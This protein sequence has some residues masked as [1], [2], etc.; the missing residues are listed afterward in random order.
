MKIA[1][2]VTASL[3]TVLAGT[4]QETDT[5]VR[6]KPMNVM[7]GVFKAEP[8][9]PDRLPETLVLPKSQIEGTGPAVLIPNCRGT[10][11]KRHKKDRYP[12][13]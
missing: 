5:S 12:F 13:A 11:T 7:M 2:L 9:K 8:V 6:C 1:I 4:S 10:E 3:F